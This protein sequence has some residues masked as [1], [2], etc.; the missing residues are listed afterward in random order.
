MITFIALCYGSLYLLIFNKL[1]LLKKTTANISAFIGVGV[2][3][4]ASI[5]FAWYTFSP[6]SS[7][8]RVTRYIIPIVPNVK[9]QLIDV[10]V[11]HL[12]R[13]KKGDVLYQIDPTPYQFKVDELIARIEQQ[14]A[15]RDLNRVNLDRAREL[16]AKKAASKY[17]Q[18]IWEAKYA[19]SAAAIAATEATLENARWQLNETTVRAPADGFPANVQ[20]RPGSY[21]TTMPVAS[22]L[23][24]VS[25]EN[26]DILTSFSQ[27]AIRHIKIGNA[28]EVVFTR[29]PGQVFAG[30]V[31]L[32]GEATAE[33]QLQ[34]SA[35][36]QTLSGA[37]ANA[38]WPVII[39]LDDLAQAT[40]LP[41]GAGGSVAVFTDTGAPFHIISKVV[42][43]MTAW[44]GYLTAP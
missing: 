2:V 39:K 9:G 5:V 42:M 30:K 43:R 25:T 18:D 31:I 12:Q 19:A 28:V 37:P 6:M 26:T 15:E 32:I 36:L 24:F 41:Q 13:V 29:I 33:S 22:S 8:A 16:V 11:T 20:L 27:S 23:A 14:S 21:V 10:S 17:E 40:A 7:D 38:R 3:M 44:T 1:K 35:T 4:I 34:A